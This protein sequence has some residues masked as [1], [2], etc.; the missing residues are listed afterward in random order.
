MVD[1]FGV[2][3]PECAYLAWS[4]FAMNASI[5]ERD[6]GGNN[7]QA[8]SFVLAV[9]EMESRESKTTRSVPFC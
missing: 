2:H 1:C 6:L 5:L 4:P 3:L 7:L 8:I 9:W